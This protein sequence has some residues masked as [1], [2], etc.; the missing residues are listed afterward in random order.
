MIIDAH[1]HAFPDKVAVKAIPKLA[2][3]CKLQ[4][5]CDGTIS[6][7][8]EKIKENHL[9]MGLILN[10]ATNPSQQTHINDWSYEISK[11]PEIQAF[12]SVHPDAPDALA[13]LHR[14]KHLGLKGVKLHPCYQGYYIDDPKAFP[15]YEE[16]SYLELPVVFHAGYDPYAPNLIHASPRACLTVHKNFP[17]LTVVFAHMGGI[18]YWKEAQELLIGQDVY[19]DTAM[20]AGLMD[21]PLAMEMISKHGAERVLFGSDFPWHDSTMELQMIDS[22]PLPQREKDLILGENAMRVFSL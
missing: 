19:L 2:S 20:C 6:Q 7:T 8:I 9:D 5:V 18:K 21:T 16:C 11:Y 3:V 17:K 22:W 14:I 4:N 15:I 12:G 1:M 13:E 10:I